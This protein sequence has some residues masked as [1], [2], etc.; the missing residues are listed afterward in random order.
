MVIVQLSIVYFHW[1]SCCM[2]TAV[3]KDIQ[4]LFSDE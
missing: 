4:K 3:N 1:K 2:E